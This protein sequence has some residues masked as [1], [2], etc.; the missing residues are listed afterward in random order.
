MML[1]Q[2]GITGRQSKGKGRD[3][4]GEFSIL[5]DSLKQGIV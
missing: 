2:T 1:R 5:L 4:Y 3:A